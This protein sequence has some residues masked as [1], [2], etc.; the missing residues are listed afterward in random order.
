MADGAGEGVMLKD[1]L[2]RIF[3]GRP[4]DL[5]LRTLERLEPR[6]RGLFRVLTYHRV[7]DPRGFREQMEHLA[8]HR[9]VLSMEHLLAVYRGEATLPPSAVLITFDDA[10][11]DFGDFAWPVLRA[12]GMPVTLFVPTGFPDRPDRIFW[13]DR[14]ECAFLGTPRRDRLETPAGRLP[15]TTP[16]DRRRSRARD[17]LYLKT[18]PQAEISDRAAE[19]AGRLEGPDP[20]PRILGWDALRRLKEEGVTLGAHSRNHPLM[21]RIGREEIREEVLGSLDDLRREIGEAPP[22]FCFPDGRC[23][24]ETSEVLR[25]A[26]VALAFTTRQGVNLVER[27]DPLRLRRINIMRCAPTSVLRLR[28]L[29]SG[30]RPLVEMQLRLEASPAGPP[31]RL[32]GRLTGS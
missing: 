13:W 7:N 11:R 8:A 26:G 6:R 1:L 19:I 27:T 10:D 20:E 29:D 30:L 28:L 25:E 17:K 21:D 12:L 9:R 3:E 14:V 22:I 23:S 4:G 18:L 16:S 5:A 32:D 31:R 24:S 15:L 2:A